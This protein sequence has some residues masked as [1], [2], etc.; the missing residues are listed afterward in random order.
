MGI[1]NAVLVEWGSEDVGGYFWVEDATSITDWGRKEG[2]LSLAG[3]TKTSVATQIATEWMSTRKQPQEAILVEAAP[4][5][6]SEPAVGDLI[7]VGA[8]EGLRTLGVTW[9]LT[10]DGVRVVPEVN[11]LL[12]EQRRSSEITFDRMVSVHGGRS[13]SSAPVR[14]TGSRIPSGKLD[15]VKLE[16]WSWHDDYL[17]DAVLDEEWQPQPIEEPCRIIK[18]EI[19]AE[20][21]EL[22]EDT[23]F[24][25]LL[26]GASFSPPITCTLIGTDDRALTWV[27]NPL[28]IFPGDVLFVKVTAIGGHVNGSVT[29]HAVKGA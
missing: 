22:N 11:S 8:D 10:D 29:P 9:S 12:D 3:V 24:E 28:T 23:S 1:V 18:F 15:A 21:T 26:N 13:A 14:V 19:N 6:G 7:D 16:S 20:P 4:I 27:F 17:L 5:A 25:L 2:F